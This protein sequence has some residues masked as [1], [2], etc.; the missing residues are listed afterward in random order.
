MTSSKDTLTVHCRLILKSKVKRVF[1][2]KT[3]IVEYSSDSSS[4]TTP[5]QVASEVLI[6]SKYNQ[7]V[8]VKINADSHMFDFALAEIGSEY[9]IVGKYV[10]ELQD[11]EMNVVSIYTGRKES[12]RSKYV[13]LLFGLGR[14][15]Y[16]DLI[17]IKL[18]NQRYH[19]VYGG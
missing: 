17:Q 8:E 15:Q 7:A 2:V 14:K 16:T 5:E 1:P 4:T 6:P 18:R 10:K 3:K 13:T 12:S 9:T 19:S 11:Q